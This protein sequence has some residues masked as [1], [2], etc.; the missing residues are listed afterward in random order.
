MEEKEQE[1]KQNYLRQNILDKGY[2]AN[3]FV[4]FLI[5]K[6]VKQPQIYQIGL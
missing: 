1:E 6:R 3:E 4:S 2:D 5:S